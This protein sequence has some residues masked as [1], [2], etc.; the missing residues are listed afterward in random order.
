MALPPYVL[1]NFTLWCDCIKDRELETLT[2]EWIKNI[3]KLNDFLKEYVENACNVDKRIS[4]IKLWE[5]ISKAFT[6]H[7]TIETFKNITKQVFIYSL[8]LFNRGLLFNDNAPRNTPASRYLIQVKKCVNLLC[9]TD[10]LRLMDTVE[11][12]LALAAS[13]AI[14]LNILQ[15]CKDLSKKAIFVNVIQDSDAICKY[16]EYYDF[17][18]KEMQGPFKVYTIKS[19]IEHM[20]TRCYELIVVSYPYTKLSLIQLMKAMKCLEWF[21]R[22]KLVN[23]LIFKI[24]KNLLQT[25]VSTKQILI[26]YANVVESL[27]FFDSSFV[28]VHRVC[29]VIKDYVITRP[30]TIKTIIKFITM[31]RP[32]ENSSNY[33]NLIFSENQLSSVNDEYVLALEETSKDSWDEWK[34]DPH[35]ANPY[36]SRLYRQ[37]ADVFS[38]LVMIYGSKEMF[39][40]EY[41][42]FLASRLSINGWRRRFHEELSYVDMMK[43]RFHEGELTQCEVMLKD[44]EDSETFCKC[45]GFFDD[46]E[47]RIISKEYWPQKEDKAFALTEPFQEVRD[48]VGRLYEHTRK[49]NR[50]LRWFNNYGCFV[51]LSCD[52]GDISVQV[53]VPISHYLVIKAFLENETVDIDDLTVQLGWEK[54]MFAEV[55]DWWIQQGCLTLDGKF[56]TLNDDE[57]AWQKLEKTAE[58]QQKR[59]YER[60]EFEDESEDESDEGDD[61]GQNPRIDSME[62]FWTYSRN[63]LKISSRPHAGQ[64][65]Q[66]VTS[67]RLLA[68]FTMLSS[69]GK[70]PLTLEEVH[71]FM[72][73]KI[74]ANLVYLDNGVY[75]LTPEYLATLND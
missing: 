14:N 6:E 52:F 50:K 45:F 7:E 55:I 8:Q 66:Q 63:M 61:D 65:V 24:R 3:S 29:N 49:N 57:V 10:N 30:D 9:T 69:P 25:S 33:C 19:F 72:N 17:R 71:T 40:K 38:M 67:E 37:S 35:D 4:A 44:M 68:I 51:N 43:N 22:E 70:P 42:E 60:G 62:S 20:I 48:S 75:K 21:G 26:S 32:G 73:R 11:E 54:K 56:A 47:I 23:A 28:L 59:Y 1:D 41:H 46:I 13:E 64:Y 58:E 36:E 53:D 16:M 34:P 2:N 74:R 18:F 12:A 39:V 15:R 5:E 27:T 31:E